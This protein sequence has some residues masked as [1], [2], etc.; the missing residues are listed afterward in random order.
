MTGNQFRI[1]TATYTNMQCGQ[2]IYS[3][4]LA[5]NCATLLL[6]EMIVYVLIHNV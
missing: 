2:K 6:S 3:T 5:E 1:C 4:P